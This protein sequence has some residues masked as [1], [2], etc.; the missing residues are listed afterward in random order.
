M[1]YEEELMSR[2]GVSDPRCYSLTCSACGKHFPPVNN[3]DDCS[4]CCNAQCLETMTA[5]DIL[6]LEG[7]L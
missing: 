1:S 4:P 6:D 7:Q 3:G 2:S 5:E